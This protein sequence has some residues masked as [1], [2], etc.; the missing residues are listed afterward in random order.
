MDLTFTDRTYSEAQPGLIGW[1]WGSRLLR[2]LLP[3]HLAGHGPSPGATCC[4][5]LPREPSPC[6]G[7]ATLRARIGALAS[8]L[9][10]GYYGWPTLPVGTAV[11]V[12]VPQSHSALWLFPLS[13]DTSHQLPSILPYVR[14]GPN[15]LPVSSLPSSSQP[16]PQAPPSPHKP[17][18]LHPPVAPSLLGAVTHMQVHISVL[19]ER[20]LPETA[21][22]MHCTYL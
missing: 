4:W 11:G 3:G 5:L 16:L 2:S 14:T 19:S 7:S 10:L 21:S 17:S 1:E 12:S 20:F 18:W 8:L 15:P 13:L 22:S 6:R 9:F